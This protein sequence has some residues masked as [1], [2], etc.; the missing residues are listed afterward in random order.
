MVVE[1]EVHHEGDMVGMVARRTEQCKSFGLQHSP[2]LPAI[3]S[4][5]GYSTMIVIEISLSNV[6]LAI[7]VKGNIL[8]FFGS[9]HLSN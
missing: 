9:L 4:H 3:I 1:E 6:W 8:L 2:K 7:P 5:S